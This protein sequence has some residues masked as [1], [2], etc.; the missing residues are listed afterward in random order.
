MG[1]VGA[2]LACGAVRQAV[3]FEVTDGELD[4]GVV[5]VVG[6]GGDGVEVVSVSYVA[7][8]APVRPQFALGADEVA[9]VHYEPQLAEFRAAG[10]GPVVMVV[11]QTWTSPCSV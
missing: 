2:E 6:V 3:V 9:A 4:S 11:S 1:G 5:A 10:S 7:V 8:V